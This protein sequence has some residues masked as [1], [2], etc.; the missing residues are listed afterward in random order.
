MMKEKIKHIFFDLDNTLWDTDKNSKT[1][2]ETMF[3]EMKVT[4]KYGLDFSDFYPNYYVR[5]EKLWDLYRQNLATKQDIISKRFC[6]TF[7][8]FDINDEEL[9]QYFEEN[10]LKKVVENNDLVEN[11]ENALRYLKSNNYN[12]HI[13][14]NGFIEPTERKVF[15]TPIHQYVSTVTSGE[16]INKRKPARE[17]FELGLQKARALPE[18]SSF[19]GDDWSADALGSEKIG[20][21]PVFFDYKKEKKYKQNGFPIVEDLLELKNIF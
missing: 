7:Q 19:V 16:E 17:V 21:F 3:S 8:E 10:F 13:V 9:N 2:L 18:E 5:N 20:M 11:A 1:T 6:S 14:S 15:D 4:E 12:L